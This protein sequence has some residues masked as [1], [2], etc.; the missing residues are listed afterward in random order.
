[1]LPCGGKRSCGHPTPRQ[2]VVTARH[3][4]PANRRKPR[5]SFDELL[6]SGWSAVD[7]PSAR[8]R[9]LER[10]PYVTVMQFG[11]GQGG[12]DVAMAKYALDDLDAR[13][14]ELVGCW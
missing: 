12:A 6:F 3:V 2:L 7:G 1:M 4:W 13:V 11:I 14:W 5:A 9:T 10:A 8:Q